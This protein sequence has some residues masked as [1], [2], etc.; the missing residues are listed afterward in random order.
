MLSLDMYFKM[1]PHS[2]L[3]FVLMVFIMLRDGGYLQTNKQTNPPNPNLY[4]KGRISSPWFLLVYFLYSLI[5]PRPA[6]FLSCAG[7]RASSR[8]CWV[9]VIAVHLSR[10]PDQRQTRER[11]RVFH[12]K[13][14]S[15]PEKLP[16]AEHKRNP[17]A[18]PCC[19]CWLTDLLVFWMEEMKVKRS[20]INLLFRLEKS[21]FQGSRVASLRSF[22]LSYPPTLL[23]PQREG[24]PLR[25][26]ARVV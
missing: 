13:R 21:Y 1:V 12:D 16:I 9:A 10:L 14:Q 18:V 23:T 3:W 2:N 17:L 5:V 20:R 25:N 7:P 26:V 24:N 22:Y 15:S 19:P 8:S 6:P 11:L 4:L